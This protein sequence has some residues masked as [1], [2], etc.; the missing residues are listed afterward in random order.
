MRMRGL[1]FDGRISEDFK[2]MSGT[3]VHATN[4]R[5]EALKHFA[6][7]ALDVVITGHDREEIGLLVF[8]HPGP[9]ND[10]VLRRGER[11]EFSARMPCAS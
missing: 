9:M 8:P 4:I 3:W 11:A 1:D 7:I 5:L 6:D 2:L 10:P